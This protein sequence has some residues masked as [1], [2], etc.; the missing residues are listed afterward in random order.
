MYNRVETNQQPQNL[1]ISS[2]WYLVQLLFFSSYN[3]SVPNDSHCILYF[4]CWSGFGMPLLGKTQKKHPGDLPPTVQT[5][6][7]HCKQS[8]SEYIHTYVSHLSLQMKLSIWGKHVVTYALNIKSTLNKTH[9]SV[10]QFDEHN[11]ALSTK[12]SRVWILLILVWIDD[13]LEGNS[14]KKAPLSQKSK[15]VGGFRL[16]SNAVTPY[17]CNLFRRKVL[18]NKRHSLFCWRTDWVSMFY[19]ALNAKMGHFRDVAP[20]QSLSRYWKN[21]FNTTKPDT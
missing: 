10:P 8:F 5:T 19:M 2:M 18:K 3:I 6:L 17:K 7:W 13:N 20:S 16:P 12:L 4:L 9:H 1:F 11:Y 21:K 14:A 15:D